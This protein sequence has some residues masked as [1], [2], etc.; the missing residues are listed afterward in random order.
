M[1]LIFCLPISLCLS[2][3]ATVLF[4]APVS[5]RL[6][7]GD[8]VPPVLF[9]KLVNYRQPTTTL[10]NFKGKVVVLD[11]WATWCGPCIKGMPALDSLQAQFA[12]QLQVIPISTE[13]AAVVKAFL[14]RKKLDQL[15]SVVEE[16][17]VQQWFPYISIPHAVIID[18]RGVVAAITT[19]AF[20]TEK[21]INDVLAG[22]P[23]N[24]HTK[25]DLLGFDRNRSLLS[26]DRVMPKDNVLFYSM[27]TGPVPGLNSF[28]SPIIK[29]NQQIGLHLTNQ[30]IVKLY[31]HATGKPDWYGRSRVVAEGIS[32]LQRYSSQNLGSVAAQLLWAGEYGYCYEILAPGLSKAAML[33]QMQTD[34]EK[35]FAVRFGT[36]FSYEKRNIPCLRLV[37]TGTDTSLFAGKGGATKIVSIQEK[38]LV[39]I[40]N[41]KMAAFAHYLETTTTLPVLDET[42]FP[43]SLDLLIPAAV[44]HAASN[45][46]NIEPFRKLLRQKGL[47]LVPG[48]GLFEVLVISEKTT[49]IQ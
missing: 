21:V 29:N 8:T 13:K 39:E 33:Q 9:Q 45:S 12:G 19:S 7:V 42:G 35:T 2:L 48:T 27:I 40:S 11:F 34:L 41:I 10:A 47:D 22:L 46:K 28:N 37:Q 20:I 30:S 5:R 16:T 23:A 44:S 1:K 26:E 15:F 38:D 49:T 18:A 25:N 4:A 14:Q 36:R 6:A 43:G 32:S 17:S 3:W 24:I 31:L